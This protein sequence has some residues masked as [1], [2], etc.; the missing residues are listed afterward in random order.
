L[1]DLET[2]TGISL[3]ERV[4][5]RLVP[6]PEG[7]RFGREVEELFLKLSH[8]EHV[9][10]EI[11]AK[12]AGALRIASLPAL[13]MGLIPQQLAEFRRKKEI[14]AILSVVPS[15]QVVEM[16]AAGEADIGFAYPVPGTPLTLMREPLGVLAAVAALPLKHPLG[17]LAVL[18]P[19][20][21]DGEVFVSLG[22]QD[23]AR[24]NMEIVFG[25]SPFDAAVAIETPFAAVACEFVAAGAGVAL[26]D[27]VTAHFY[28]TRVLVRP[29]EPGFSFDFGALTLAGQPQSAVTQDFVRSVAK[30]IQAIQREHSPDAARPDR[31]RAHHRLKA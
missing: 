11:R 1:Q 24:D 19:A 2:S 25:K 7:R 4:R 13:G 3:F 21:F 17:K 28:R 20:D 8:V 29:V 6:T 27:A 31:R 26:V 16:V 10:N 22:R 23:H 5:K 14:R 9:A 18:Q 30:A 12:G 15:Q